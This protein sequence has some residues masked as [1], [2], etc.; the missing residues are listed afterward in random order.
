MHRFIFVAVAILLPVL[1]NAQDVP[2]RISQVGEGVYAIVG[3]TG[4]R[5]PTNFGNNATFGAIVTSDGVVMV[6]PGGSAKGAAMLEK[7]IQTVTDKPIIAVIN[8]G[9][10]DHRW[11]GN[12]YFKARGARIIASVDAVA[13]QKERVND[14]LN[15]LKFFIG[16]DGLLGT[17]P[18]HAEETFEDALDLEIGGVRIQIRHSVGAHTPGDAFVWLPE[19][20]IMFSGDI[21]YVDRILSVGDYSDSAAWIDAFNSMAA[22][23]PKVVVP[24]HGDPAPLNKAR[25]QT[26][27]Y[28]KNLRD[29]IGQVINKDGAIEDAISI[30]QSAFAGLNN[31]SQLAKR[32]AQQVFIHMEFE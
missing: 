30:D 20:N 9:G 32:N 14:Q 15:G 7:I 13:D 19:M 27:N 28:L 12:D 17:E 24:G 22:L 2:L 23:S 1:A 6:D 21:A 26:L 31:F 25:A 5:S 3:E 11:L 10:Q 18:I 8:T 29:K 16:A 4:Q